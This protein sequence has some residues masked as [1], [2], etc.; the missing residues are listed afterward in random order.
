MKP[1]SL[2]DAREPETDRSHDRTQ[3]DRSVRFPVFDVRVLEKGFF[4]GPVSAAWP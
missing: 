3:G 1:T 4:T 2:V